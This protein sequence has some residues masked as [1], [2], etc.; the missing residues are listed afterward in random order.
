MTTVVNLKKEKYDV[1][2]GRGSIFGSPY[3][4]GR[5]G[6]REQ[7]IERYK[8][9]FN[10]LLRDSI[11]YNALLNL[12]DKRLACFCKPL[13]CHCDIIAAHVNNYYN[14]IDEL[15]RRQ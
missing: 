7:V 11:F 8:E 3:I 4:L 13:S 5:D 12:K 15:N 6:T 2:C 10:F 9:W 1:Y 14:A